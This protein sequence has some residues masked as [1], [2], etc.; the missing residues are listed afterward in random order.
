VDGKNV[1]KSYDPETSD[2]LDDLSFDLNSK[3]YYIGD[4]K[5]N[6][7]PKSLRKNK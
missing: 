2:L 4:F 7:Y 3:K 1:L 5:E 6:D